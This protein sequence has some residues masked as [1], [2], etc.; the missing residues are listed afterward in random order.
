MDITNNIKIFENNHRKK[1]D[2]VVR[3]ANEIEVNNV[4]DAKLAAD[5]LKE[6]N[7]VI[8]WIDSERKKILEPLK[9]FTNKL[10]LLSKDIWEPAQH[11]KA[12]IKSKIL[13]YNEEIEKIRKEEELRVQKEKEEAIRRELE[14]KRKIEEAEKLK[15]EEEQR[16]IDQANEKEKSELEEK[17][18]KERREREQEQ[19]AEKSRLE[20]KRKEQER[21]ASMRWQALWVASKEVKPKWVRKVVKFEISNNSEVPRSYCEPSEKII[22]D[23]VKA[24]IKEI[25]WV[26]IREETVVQ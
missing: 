1:V 15:R 18:N 12:K 23:A 26:R 11:A 16:L 8:R 13:K 22:R 17:M 19:L 20:Q 25:P 21:I 10:N 7:K 2:E 9:E 6:T 14:E 3:Q 24:W 5:A 4:T